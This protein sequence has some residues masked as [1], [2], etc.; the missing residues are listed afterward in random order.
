MHLSVST[1]SIA[2]P[3]TTVLYAVVKLSRNLFIRPAS[4]ADLASLSFLSFS[5]MVTRS[6]VAVDVKS[7]ILGFLAPKRLYVCLSSDN[8][9]ITVCMEI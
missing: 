7:G 5:M 1:H 9:G 2:C 6:S 4:I 8:K 3:D